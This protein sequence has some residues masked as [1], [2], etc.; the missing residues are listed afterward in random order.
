[1]S[2]KCAAISPVVKPFAVSDNTISS[3]PDKRAGVS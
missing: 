1:M 3:M 2:A